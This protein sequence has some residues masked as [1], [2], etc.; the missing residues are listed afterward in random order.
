MA[1]IAQLVARRSHNPKV[2]SSILTRRTSGLLPTVLVCRFGLCCC[3]GQTGRA[4]RAGR[5]G[6]TGRAPLRGRGAPRRGAPRRG[7]PRAPRAP[8][9]TISTRVRRACAA[10]VRVVHAC[11]A[12][13]SGV[14]VAHARC[15]CTPR[16]RVG[17]VRRASGV[18][19]RASGTHAGA[20]AHARMRA[21]AH[22]R[23]GVCTGVNACAHM[24]D[25]WRRASHRASPS[26][27]S[28]V[29]PG[30]AMHGVT[31][32]ARLPASADDSARLPPKLPVRYRH[33]RHHHH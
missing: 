2:V 6:R 15:A 14:H 12:C 11:R 19:R 17:R 10:R 33:Y 7:A 32:A 27:A 3:A 4:G 26:L 29:T 24:C 22:V 5:A 18:A 25:A 28:R 23:A 13:T 20:R 21:C 1:V 16:V 8:Q 9:I 30:T 31:H